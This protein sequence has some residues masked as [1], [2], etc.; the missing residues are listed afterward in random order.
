MNLVTGNTGQ[1]DENSAGEMSL[2]N[3][4][5]D[6]LQ[7]EVTKQKTQLINSFV[8]I[9]P[10]QFGVV[11][12]AKHMHASKMYTDSTKTT[13]ANDDTKGFK[14]FF[15]YMKNN[16]PYE[17][18]ILPSKGYLITE[19]LVI[20]EECRNIDFNNSTFY[21]FGE[22]NTYC[23]S[24]G[25]QVLTEPFE[26]YKGGYVHADWRNLIITGD[27]NDSR[28][29]NGLD[30]IRLNNSKFFNF[31]IQHMNIG[32][33]GADTWASSVS[34]F[35]I[36]HSNLGFRTGRACNGTNFSKMDI[37][38]CKVGMEVGKASGVGNGN[39]GINGLLIDGGSLFQTC[40]TAIELHF[41]KQMTV[42]DTYF[43]D[44]N[45]VI[46]VPSLTADEVIM[47]FNFTSNL[48]DASKNKECFLLLRDNVRPISMTFTQNTFTGYKYNNTLFHRSS[49][50]GGV[51][52]KFVVSKNAFLSNMGFKDIFP[53]TWKIG[54][55]ETDI[56]FIPEIDTANWT[57]VQPIQIFALGQKRFEISGVVKRIK[58][59][60]GKS[61]CKVPYYFTSDKY[62]VYTR[63]SQMSQTTI[64]M[65][66]IVLE[67]KSNLKVLNLYALDNADLNV[68]HFPCVTWCTR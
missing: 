23:L 27:H 65:E 1:P 68:I 38:N 31:R 49:G 24:G 26:D 10:A 66:D 12:N 32:V 67:A 28:L 34:N 51:I 57:V 19:T 40:D 21:F 3:G 39:W 9:N 50:I 48:V 8:Q 7:D 52:R 43:E 22:K 25:A 58:G 4:R 36:Y 59:S 2:I 44:N 62:N 16:H 41:I 56:P 30:I 64:K 55:T 42:R 37:M 61:L 33:L 17:Q 54:D 53:D 5:L 47:N 11:G 6:N 46:D 15:E 13:L 29:C 14:A 60:T 45:R 20:P 63:A 35:K 18:I